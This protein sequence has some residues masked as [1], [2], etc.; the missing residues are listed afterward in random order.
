M[1]QSKNIYKQFCNI[2]FIYLFPIMITTTIAHAK[3]DPMSDEQIAVFDAIK[4]GKNVVVDACAGSGKSTTILSIATYMPNHEFIQLTYN[5]MLCAEIKTKADALGLSNIKIYT[6]HSL[7]VRYYSNSGYTDTM[8]RRVLNVNGPPK[9]PIPRFHI[10]V[11]DETQDM[12]MLYFKLVVK[13][14]KD[15][16]FPIQLLILGDFMQGLYEFK[17]AD[18]RFLTNATEIWSGFPLLQCH[19]F[20]KCTLKMSYRITC[21]MADFVNDVMLGEKRL[22]ACKHG[23]PV[24]YLRRSVYDAEKYVVYHITRLLNECGVSPSDIFVLGSS[25]KGVRSAIRKMENA[26]VEK[27]VPCHVPMMDTEKIDERVIQGKVV[28]STF[29]SV[30][31]RQRKYVFVMGFD[32]SYFKFFARNLPTNVCPNTL[33]VACT[34][35]THGLVIIEN[36]N[37]RED[38]PLTFLKMTHAEMQRHPS[39]EFKGLPQTVFYDEEVNENKIGTTHYITPTELIKFIPE[40]VIEKILPVLEKIFVKVNDESTESMIDIPT[41]VET[42]SKFHEDVSDLNGIAIPLMYFD[43]MMERHDKSAEC[44]SGGGKLLHS[45]IQ[46]DMDAL[47]PNEHPFLRKTVANLPKICKTIPDYLYVSNVFVAVREKLYFKINQISPNEYTWL[48]EE[49]INECFE[50][51]HN[52]L[53]CEC[54]GDTHYSDAPSYNENV[55]VDEDFSVKI[56]KTIVN[57]GDDAIHSKIDMYL[58]EYFPHEAFRFTARVDAITDKSV[59]EIKCVGELTNDHFLQVVIYAW[60]W[61]LCIE[62][63]QHLENIRDFRIFNIRSGEIYRLEAETNELS[64]IVVELLKAKYGSPENTDN[65]E[66]IEKCREIQCL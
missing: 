46:S 40:N 4:D 25:V 62:D 37:K 20:V 50:R 38:R 28:F 11:I 5:S 12:T 65:Y 17:G 44:M 1:N 63:I 39:I 48:S 24:V 54:I 52:I 15:H 34:R 9:T 18:T 42:K 36:H 26:L 45:I 8:I 61:R 58:R 59:W 51:I 60:L 49:V 16:G 31:G 57:A 7:A 6:Y 43:K 14:C 41:V 22:Y 13:F 10:L 33:Y 19:D 21:E 32:Q 3:L 23:A 47:K 53:Y 35:A 2:L 27:N 66:F 64:Y 56:E 29:H 55:D 30:K